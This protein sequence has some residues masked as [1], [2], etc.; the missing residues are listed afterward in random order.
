MRVLVVHSNFPPDFMGGGEYIVGE[1]TIELK[2]SGHEV[3]VITTGDPSDTEWR[4]IPVTR[5]PISRYRFNAAIRPIA[6]AARQ[7]DIIQTF[8]F[9]GATPAYVAGRLTNTPVV[10]E[11]LGLFGDTWLDMRGPV[12]GRIYRWWETRL[13]RWKYDSLVYLSDYSLDI[14]NRLGTR[15]RASVA[16]YPGI[17]RRQCRADADKSTVL[18][19]GKLE[20]RKGLYTV[21]EVARQLPDI[22]FELVGWSDDIEILRAEAPANV[23]VIG[24]LTGDPLFDAYARAR[25]FFFPS[26]AETF[27]LVIVEAMASGCAVV[28]SVPLPFEGQLVDPHDSA[29]M[30]KHIRA[31]WDSPEACAAAGTENQR[32]ASNYTWERH[33]AVLLEQ[34]KRCLGQ[35]TSEPDH[36]AVSA[37]TNESE[38]H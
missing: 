27:G 28:S 19:V 30:V 34:Y 38:K 36:A 1:I 16:N 8:T 31:L 5:L 14:G 9:H 10:C 11:V 23:N 33:G 15:A 18:F 26:F 24:K 29:A 2:R 37:V 20:T 25:I 22:P 6:R 32:R 3:S 12:I 13:M 7:A 4:G 21:L 35:Q 17:E